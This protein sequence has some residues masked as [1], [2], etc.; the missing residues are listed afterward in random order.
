[1][2]LDSLASGMPK[3]LPKKCCK[4]IT[5]E[6]EIGLADAETNQGGAHHG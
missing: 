5:P 6:Q 1:M 3:I 4:R 2:Q